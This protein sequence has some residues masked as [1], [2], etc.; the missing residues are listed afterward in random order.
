MVID[1]T[2]RLTCYLTGLACEENID[3]ATLAYLDVMVRSA[4]PSQ[5]I[6][7]VSAVCS[8]CVKTAL[9]L[10]FRNAEGVERSHTACWDR[11]TRSAAS[12]D[13]TEIYE[14]MIEAVDRK[15]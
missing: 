6:Q 9:V 4:N 2:G 13:A 14:S 12:D 5:W 3:V 8:D 1:S 11:V 15:P 7:S 10:R